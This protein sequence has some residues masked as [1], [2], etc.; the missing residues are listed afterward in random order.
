MWYEWLDLR[1]LM[2]ILGRTRTKF[3]IVFEGELGSNPAQ[4]PD[5]FQ[6]ID[7]LYLGGSGEGR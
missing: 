1:K 6:L 2:K 3:Q 5:N 7:L 4:F